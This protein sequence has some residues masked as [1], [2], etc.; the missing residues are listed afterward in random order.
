MS[1]TVTKTGT[2]IP[3]KKR[4]LYFG[5]DLKN[6]DKYNL[7]FKDNSISTTKYNAFTFIP[8]SLLLQFLRA[9]NIYF[10]II[11]I[12]TSLPFSTRSPTTM[13]GTFALVLIFTMLKEGYED[14]KR[15]QADKLINEKEALV[16]NY[17]TKQFERKMWWKIRVGEII[18][19][20]TYEEIPC[21]LMCL[22]TSLKTG[23]CFLDTMNLDGETNLKERMTFKETKL[24]SDDEIIGMS[25]KI[26]CDEADEN[27]EKWD[28]NAE[29]IG[30]SFTQLVANSKNIILKGCTL[31]MKAEE[32]I[33]GVAIY[34]GHSTKIMKNAKPPK[35][36]T[37]NV[38][39]IMNILLYSLF[40]FLI[41]L[42]LL[43]SLL[44]LYWQNKYGKN[45]SFL[46]S[47]DEDKNFIKPKTDGLA[48]FIKFLVFI[49]GY[50]HIIPISLYVGLE[51]LK[52]YQTQLIA[53]DPKM[54]DPETENNALARTS[55]LIEELGQVEFIFS[56]KTG[57]LTKNEMIFR[58]CSINNVIYGNNTS[59]ETNSKEN[60]YLLNG[61]P[62]CFNVIK[63]FNHQEYNNVTDFFNICSVCHEAYIE[64]KHGT[65]QSSSPDEVALIEGGKMVGFNFK[66]KTPGT[67]ETFIEHTQE[68]IIWEVSLVLKFDSTRKRMSVIV[69]K[70]KSDEYWL[71]TKGADTQMLAAMTIPQNKLSEINSH[72]ALFAK[73][74]LR[75][76]VMAKKQLKKNEVE[77]Y[78][79]RFNDISSST[80][81]SRDS[82]LVNLFNEIEKGFTYVGCSAIEDKLQDNVGSTI[83]NL[84]NANIRVWVLTG[85]KKETALEIGKS[86]K[87]V[88]PNTVM[89]EIDLANV[90]D[91]NDTLDDVKSKIDNYFY[92]FY[93]DKE[94]EAID[95]KE[96]YTDKNLIRSNITKKM[97]TIIDGLN[98]AHVLS[99]DKLS[100]KF[101]R[102]G[103]LC[104]SVICCRVSPKQKSE[105]VSL[106]QK[107][108]TW[109]TLSVGDGA[110]DVPM[111]LTAN[112]GIGIC[113]KEGTQ[114]VRSADYAIGQFQFL[115][116]ILFTHGRWGY[117]RVSLFIYYYFYK[118]IL[119]VFVELYFAFYSGFSG[120]SF[121]PDFLPLCYN[122]L[123][124]SWPCMFCYAIERDV[125]EET[126]MK[127]PILYEAG[128]KKKYF[129]LKN[130]W[131]W[132]LYALIHG[133]LIFYIG[134]ECIE[135][136]LAKDG[137]THDNWLK[138][139]ILFSVIVHVVTYKIYI[140]LRYWNIFNL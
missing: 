70:E 86:C 37:S 114:A 120:Q 125:E 52:M 49:I 134:L 24:L 133:V 33:I 18:K 121:F 98:L 46:W 26:V 109:I 132:I 136:F 73:E 95:K 45:L 113:G 93:S 72:L 74:A 85:D 47:Y 11:C 80:S 66:N 99:D 55:D 100:R 117:R 102:I 19:T 54:F 31:R 68:K 63:N 97:F 107:N 128:Q 8:K 123:W 127:C 131:I 62:S 64:E 5:N 140:E 16:Y 4:K 7:Y 79:R 44:Y 69:N 105:V 67:I 34:T 28:A 1:E 104:N 15:Y 90:G 36:K 84:M 27:L 78:V 58:K 106:A 6:H 14:I 137:K 9:A 96:M 122:A 101:F 20:L 111:I 13:C 71:F 76:L 94:N 129:N 32:Y 119:L 57:T 12:L 42:C 25:G 21:D 48:W 35:P 116:K 75:T 124:T 38:M 61:D 126:S 108:G 60:K 91:K 40:F 103:L 110:N 2:L 112:I 138:S 43:F 118:N 135:I 139:T 56:D 65:V 53:N 83:E 23:M 30:M 10:L 41:I 59:N 130:F 87:L 89:E 50:S 22:K 77:D 3:H 115:Q 82:D 17:Q 51:V 92:R 29:I 88:H 39:H 81:E